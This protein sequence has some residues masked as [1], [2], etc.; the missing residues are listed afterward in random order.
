MKRLED[1]FTNQPIQED[2]EKLCDPELL[3]D[4]HRED[5]N[6]LTLNFVIKYLAA[7]LEVVQGDVRGMRQKIRWLI[8]L[9]QEV[10]A[11]DLS[12]VRE[13]NFALH[14]LADV[15]QSAAIFKEVAF[16]DHFEARD[17]FIGLDIGSGTG[18]LMMA[19][20]I[21]ARRKGIDQ[22]LCVGIER[23]KKVERQSK[24]VMGQIVDPQQIA[25][26]NENAMRPDLL[27]NMF[28][29][30]VPNYWVSE[31]ISRSTPAIDLDKPDFGLS[32]FDITFRNKHEINGDPFVEVLD[33]SLAELPAFTKKVHQGKVAMFPDIFNGF[34]RPDKDHS[35][36][37][38]K[39]G[40]DPQKPLK[41]EDVDEEF[42][43]YEDFD[44]E[45]RR[46]KGREEKSP[47]LSFGF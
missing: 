14:C 46:W 5:V 29:G 18:I 43:N 1:Y 47:Q 21:A 2:F 22:I 40:E 42:M 4:E 11:K 37:T 15:R 12:A 6:H 32:T 28:D 23:V 45:Y 3:F 39:T 34:Y 36:L 35:R 17:G 9:R 27:R 20:A 33:K 44:L 25:V 30:S 8:E 16:N 38:L 24:E 7:Y 10:D 26:L 19:M 31:T 13:E 41:L